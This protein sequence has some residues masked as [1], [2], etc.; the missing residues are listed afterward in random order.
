MHLVSHVKP[1]RGRDWVSCARSTDEKRKNSPGVH[2]RPRTAV[3][4]ERGVNPIRV[5]G[6]Q[7]SGTQETKAIPCA[8]ASSR[9]SNIRSRALAWG[10]YTGK[11]PHRTPPYVRSLCPL[12]FRGQWCLPRGSAGESEMGDWTLNLAPAGRG[13]HPAWPPTTVDSALFSVVSEPLPLL[14]PHLGSAVG[15]TS[16]SPPTIEIM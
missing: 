3:P 16:P 9:T 7:G 12:D 10:G 5:S 15:R 4:S 13:P 11:V 2:I 14:A 1:M 6:K 8:S